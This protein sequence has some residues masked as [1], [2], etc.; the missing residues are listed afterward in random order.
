M[1]DPVGINRILDGCVENLPPCEVAGD[2]RAFAYYGDDRRFRFA[3]GRIWKPHH[4]PLV[5]CM[6]NPSTADE[7]IVDPTVRKCLHYAQ[8]DGFGG[9]I[10]VN[11]FAIRATDPRELAAR[12][13][14]TKER[15]DDPRNDVVVQQALSIGSPYAAWGAPKW[16]FAYDRAREVIA[17]A[18]SWRCFGV[19][20]DGH[21]R[22]P[23][24]L[25]NDAQ[26]REWS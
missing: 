12:M 18:K 9:L 11:L 20:N 22:H 3:L 17:M 10:V 7:R 21:P 23:L 1:L 19:T 16:R 25:P 4:S 14:D 26:A 15:I 24:Y 2:D 13:F 5:V 8:R 6:L